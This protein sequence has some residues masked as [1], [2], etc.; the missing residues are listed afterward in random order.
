V[1][2][3]LAELPGRLASRD[4]GWETYLVR[5][6]LAYHDAHEHAPATPMGDEQ[7][8]A[9]HGARVRLA[10]AVQDVLMGP[11]RL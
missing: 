10:R 5:L 7:P 3:V 6:A 4:P 8:G 2:R 9:V 1:L 11:D